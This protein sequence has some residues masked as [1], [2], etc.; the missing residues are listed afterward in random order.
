VDSLW[1]QLSP[2]LT[3]GV[4]EM[5]QKILEDFVKSSTA[6]SEAFAQQLKQQRN[7]N[8]NSYA[9]MFAT[10]LAGVAV[11]GVIGGIA[12][13]GDVTTLKSDM[14][15]VKVSLKEFGTKLDV[16]IEKMT[17]HIIT[18]ESRKKDNVKQ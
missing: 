2:Q 5:D 13:Y 1:G 17:T 11:A 15:T 4:I 8:G 9:G 7:G 10:F 18:E 3:R 14:S 12:V 6:V 16:Q